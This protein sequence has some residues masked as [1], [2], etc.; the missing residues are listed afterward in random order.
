[1]WMAIWEW[2]DSYKTISLFLS[3]QRKKSN[4]VFNEECNTII[5][6]GNELM[7]QYSIDYTNEEQLN[8]ISKRL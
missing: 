3:N 5:G 2:N 4:Y 7:Q 6:L 1:M 8:V